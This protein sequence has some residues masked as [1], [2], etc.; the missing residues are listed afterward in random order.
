MELNLSGQQTDYTD[1]APKMLK[2]KNRMDDRAVIWARLPEKKKKKWILNVDDPIMQ[3]AWDIS[4]YLAR[5]F[6]DLLKEALRVEGT[7]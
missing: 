3:L 4:K 7:D 2:L 6:P 5:K 1:I